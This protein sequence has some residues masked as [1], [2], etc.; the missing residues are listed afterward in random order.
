MCPACQVGEL[1]GQKVGTLP[2]NTKERRG[3]SR[4][5]TSECNSQVK[6]FQQRTPVLRHASCRRKEYQLPT[7][8]R[9]AIFSATK[10]APKR[11][12][13]PPGCLK[14]NCTNH[15]LE[16]PTQGTRS[17]VVTASTAF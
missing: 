1:H 9:S 7:E 6:L 12:P 15:G 11:D 14:V 16:L 13:P 4:A 17:Q 10:P 3:I 5:G 8:R 2:A